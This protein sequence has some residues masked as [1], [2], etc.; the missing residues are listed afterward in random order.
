MNWLMILS[1]TVNILTFPRSAQFNSDKFSLPCLTWNKKQ[2]CSPRFC[3]PFFG[4][5]SCL[6]NSINPNSLFSSFHKFPPRARE[7]VFLFLSKHQ[8]IF[9]LFLYS[10]RACCRSAHIMLLI[11][12]QISIEIVIL[13]LEKNVKNF[14]EKNKF[15]FFVKQSYGKFISVKKFLL[16]MEQALFSRI[17]L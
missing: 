10:I 15:F 17:K 7:I 5:N 6:I 12:S 9:T 16:K 3:F 1:E 11:P 14:C 8:N 13:V 2:N 4:V